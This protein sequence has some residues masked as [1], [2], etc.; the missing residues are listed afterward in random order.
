MLGANV[1]VYFFVGG[2]RRSPRPG[3]KLS[4]SQS[5]V[6]GSKSARERHATRLVREE[7]EAGRRLD[8][9]VEADGLG[10][11]RTRRGSMPT[12]EQPER[13][14]ALRVPSF[15]RREARSKKKGKGAA[16]RQSPSQCAPECKGNAGSGLK[17]IAQLARRAWRVGKTLPSRRV[18]RF[19]P[20]KNGCGPEARGRSYR[21]MWSAGSAFG[22][23]GLPGRIAR[24]DRGRPRYRRQGGL[25]RLDAASRTAAPRARRPTWTTSRSS[26]RSRTA[27]RRSP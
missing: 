6:N 23:R 10:G 17:E 25:A 5:N 18:F 4:V 14:Q 2:I 9:G 24:R 16:V 27:W 1:C 3:P 11:A 15:P 13:A 19:P 7:R 8:L 26:S 22:S 21:R 20:V 12:S